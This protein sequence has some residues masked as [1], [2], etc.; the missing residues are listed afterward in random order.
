MATNG[1][2]QNVTRE[3]NTV[4]VKRSFVNSVKADLVKREIM[5][6]ESSL[7]VRDDMAF[8]AFDETPVA[9]VLKPART[10]LGL[11]MYDSVDSITI[12]EGDDEDS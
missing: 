10:Q 2:E 9:L 3:G 8:W 12:S 5:L 11:P 7:A 6:D 4:R 1:Q